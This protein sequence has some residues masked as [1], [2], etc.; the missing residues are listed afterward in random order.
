MLLYVGV[1]WSGIQDTRYECS[2][3]SITPMHSQYT[4]NKR[5]SLWYC[6][7]VLMAS[8][9]WWLV[10]TD[11]SSHSMN[12]S[13]SFLKPYMHIGI[14]VVTS[15]EL[16]NYLLHYPFVHSECIF[17]ECSWILLL[18][19]REKKN[20]SIHFLHHHMHNFINLSHL[21]KATFFLLEKSQNLCLS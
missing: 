11:G 21:P 3:V 8:S 14:T 12:L 1:L 5:P 19:E 6:L 18:W 10:V 15:S 20:I 13:T 4:W 17:F 2:R 16:Y 7:L 9:H